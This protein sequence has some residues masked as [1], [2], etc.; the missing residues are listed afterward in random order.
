MTGGA[1]KEPG[2]VR[3]ICLLWLL[4]AATSEAVAGSLPAEP[5]ASPVASEEI[6]A[7]PQARRTPTRDKWLRVGLIWGATALD[8]A[9]TRYAISSN[10]AM[11]ESNPLLST[12]DGRFRTGVYLG[13]SLPLDAL[14]TFANLKYPHSRTIRILTYVGSLAKIGIGIQNFRHG[15]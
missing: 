2:M 12:N 5:V 4:L 13:V 9:S 1:Q 11:R 14:A 15:Q 6:G 8:L 10:P 7:A 3:F